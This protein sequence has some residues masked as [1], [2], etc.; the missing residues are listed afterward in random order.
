LP[1]TVMCCSTVTLSISQSTCAVGCPSMT[2]GERMGPVVLPILVGAI[3][4]P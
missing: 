3:D 1:P 2:I 4:C